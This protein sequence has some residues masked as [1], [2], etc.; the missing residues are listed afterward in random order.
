M[1]RA[2]EHLRAGRLA[3]AEPLLR[4]VLARTP[5]HAGALHLLGCVAFQ[6]RPPSEAEDLIRRAIAL[7]PA[8]AVFH[9]NLGLALLV[10]GRK[11][12][13]IQAFRQSVKLWP[14]HPDANNELGNV[15]CDVGQFDEALDC[16]KRAAAARPGHAPSLFNLG[17]GWLRKALA[18]PPDQD[19][20]KAPAAQRRKDDLQEAV[21]CLQ[22]ALAL[23]SDDADSAN[24]LGNAL[25]ALGR[26]DEAIA[27]WRRAAAVA[28][29]PFAFLN[30]G[31]AL[32]DQDRFDEALVAMQNSLRLRPDQPELCNNLGTLFR[33][34]GQAEEAIAWFD[35][36][37]ALQ[38]RHAM[39]HSNRLYSMYFHPNYD[40]P[41]ILHEHRLWNE[42]MA[43]PLTRFA[44]HEN[45]RSPRRR[46][47]VG[48]ISPNFREHSEAFFIVPLLANHDHRDFEIYCYSDVE[49]PDALAARLRS[50]ADAWRS[51][52]GMN[53]QQA[54][55]LIRRDKIDVLVDLTLHMAGNRMYVFAR[56]PAPVQLT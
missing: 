23:R 35:R 45:D 30:L 1:N 37:I 17:T 16:F 46:L 4:Q 38:P 21:Q 47:R 49:T 39:A 31:R 19:P 27:A 14:E 55:E 6:M 9:T 7:D 5:H 43:Q 53:D 29:N 22:R 51:T 40:G 2:A 12:D 52:A 15:L 10:M 42:Q 34:T 54:A 33:K 36:A 3:E 41:R 56:K 44:P 28:P 20:S 32:C 26:T 50:W 18:A 8:Q 48:Y 13:A 25:Q 24:N 11:D